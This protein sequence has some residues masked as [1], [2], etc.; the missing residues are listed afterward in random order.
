MLKHLSKERYGNWCLNEQNAINKFNHVGYEN[1][2]FD[3]CLWLYWSLLSLKKLLYVNKLIKCLT[4]TVYCRFSNVYEE[5]VK[6][7]TTVSDCRN[8]CYLKTNVFVSK[9]QIFPLDYSRSAYSEIVSWYYLSYS[10]SDFIYCR[11]P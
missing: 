2:N 8:V 9:L 5:A 4:N 7:Q 10:I 3:F 1:G 6:K 11:I